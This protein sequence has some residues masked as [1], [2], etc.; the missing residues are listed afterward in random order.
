MLRAATRNLVSL[1]LVLLIATVNG[2]AKRSP[3]SL[4]EP[5]EETSVELR[6]G[7]VPSDSIICF[8]LNLTSV[9]AKATNGKTTALVSKPFT[10]EIMHLAGVSEPVIFGSLPQG[11]Y[12]DIAITAN[13][14]RVTSLDPVSG[15]LVAKQLPAHYN[16]IIH[17]QPALT[18][19]ANPVALDLQVNPAQLVNAGSMGN[20]GIRNSVHLFR[21]VATQ[22][23]ASVLKKSSKGAADRIVGSVSNISGHSFTVVNGQTGAALTF[24]VDANTRFYNASLSTLKGLIVVAR[25]R[26]GRGGFLVATHVEALENA[27]GT[28][29]DGILSGYIPNSDVMT[30][31]SQD[32]AGYGMKNSIVGSGI[33]VDPSQNPHF[34][35]D[36]QDVDM[37]GL[38]SL[39]FN[40]DSLVLGQHVQVQS[41]RA[42]QRD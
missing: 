35:V 39:Q 31:A 33:S 25:G 32:G 2:T 27:N 3:L 1:I 14:A 9:T 21:L 13:G 41:M 29:M 18:V 8:R 17:F 10:I 42:M 24:S 36:A 11:Q 20:N 12:T 5:V 4:P 26:S 19:D 28:V 6:I 37:T 16:T 22:L 15:F 34:V 7:G 38:G 40:A 23:N 30:L